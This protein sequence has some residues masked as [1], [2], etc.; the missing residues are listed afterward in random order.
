MLNTVSAP[1]LLCIGAC[2]G[3]LSRWQLTLWFNHIESISALGILLANWLGCFMIGICLGLSLNDASKLMLVTGFLG[4]FTTFSSFTAE[5]VE[6]LMAQKYFD[7]ISVLCLHLL[8]GLLLTFLG[9]L[10]VRLLRP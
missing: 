4:S 7:A 2:L 8:G 5:T 6:K 3:A 1:L 9:L 10:L